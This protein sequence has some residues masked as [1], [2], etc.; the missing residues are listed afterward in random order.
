MRSDF[1]F[2]QLFP[3]LVVPLFS[4]RCLTA[5]IS[6]FLH[7]AINLHPPFVTFATQASAS[8]AVAFQPPVIPNA[9]TPL[10]MQSTHSFSFLPRP[11][12]TAPSRFTKKNAIR[13]GNHPRPIRMRVPPHRCVLSCATLSQSLPTGLSRGH[14][15]TKSSDRLVP[16]VL[17]PDDAN[18]HLLVHDAELGWSSVPGAG[19]THCI[20]TVE[21]RLTQ[22][23]AFG[24]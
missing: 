10:C 8:N 15:C 19:F 24:S 18:Q 5:F 6:S 20:H 17:C 23:L 16:L 12:R 1:S 7:A 14:G 3:S 11:L 21:P 2:E 22:P 4:W 9:R 13:F